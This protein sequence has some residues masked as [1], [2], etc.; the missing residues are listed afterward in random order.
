M[1]SQFSKDDTIANAGGI[2][3]V[4][5]VSIAA[6]E[7]EAAAKHLSDLIQGAV[8][9]LPGFL[10]GEVLEADDQRSILALTHW[11][12]RQL[13]AQAQ[14]NREV[15]RTLGEVSKSATQMVDTMYYV[16]SVAQ[17]AADTGSR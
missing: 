4:W 13:W 2:V 3:H 14:W 1:P 7:C 6:D 17:S 11:T 12:S 15:G 5:A 8:A 10:K 9:D 16:R